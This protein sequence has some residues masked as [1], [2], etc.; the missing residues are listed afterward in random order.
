LEDK[1]LQDVG[2]HFNVPHG[3]VLGVNNYSINTKPVGEIIKRHN[4][5]Y[6]CYVYNT[7][8]YMALKPYDEWDDIIFSIEACIEDII[9]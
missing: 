5:K 8:V 7:H 3:F 6:H 1:T 4:G 2:L 9:I